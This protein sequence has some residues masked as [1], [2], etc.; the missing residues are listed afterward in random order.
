MARRDQTGQSIDRRF[1]DRLQRRAD[2]AAQYGTALEDLAKA[3][4]PLYQ[5]LDD[6]QKRRFVMLAHLAD[7]HHAHLATSRR[8]NGA[9]GFNAPPG[10]NFGEQLH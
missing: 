8:G 2:A 9:L 7:R 4:K 1:A 10:R 3:A 5:S 6:A